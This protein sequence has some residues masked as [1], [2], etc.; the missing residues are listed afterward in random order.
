MVRRYKAV[1]R[2][3]N[4]RVIGE[5]VGDTFTK[6][7]RGSIHQLR[8]PRAW[9]VDVDALE[10][11]E[12]LGARWVVVVDRDDGSRYRASVAAFWER[13]VRLERGFG[14]QVALPLAYWQR[15]GAGEREVEQLGLW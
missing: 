2:S 1:V 8:A 10:E 5:V 7:V 4:G 14:P 11:A 13:G 15:T 6:Q 9:G 3:G 12:R